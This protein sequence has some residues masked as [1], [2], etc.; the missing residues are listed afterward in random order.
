MDIGAIVGIVLGIIIV[1]LI[2]IGIALFVTTYN[3]LLRL[4]NNAEE[5][6]SQLDALF[7]KRCELLPNLINVVKS[8][9][10]ED[11]FEE[12]LSTRNLALASKN[13]QE[14]LE[15]EVVLS[16]AIKAL[17]AKL[18]N[19]ESLEALNEYKSIKKDFDQLE[20]QINI[21]GSFYNDVANV[22]NNRLELFPSNWVAK[23]FKFTPK[24]LYKF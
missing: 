7:K 12:I 14:Q 17:F 24:S 22:Y 15:N 11:D 8:C 1:V 21:S 23:W 4:R 2:I 18:Q 16:D 9:V 19:N 13:V 10:K 20:K 3:I 6:F 5:A